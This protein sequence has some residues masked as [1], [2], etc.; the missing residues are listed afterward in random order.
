MYNL[1]NSNLPSYTDGLPTFNLVSDLDS[2]PNLKD[3]DVLQVSILNIIVYQNL[4][5]KHLIPKI[6]LFCIRM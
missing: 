6:S 1:I 4:L 5:L 3:N 2:I